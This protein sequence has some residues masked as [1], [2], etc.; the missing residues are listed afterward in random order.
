MNDNNIIPL[1]LR[2]HLVSF[3]MKELVG[4]SR[5][6]AG[7]KCSVHQ[8]ERHSFIYNYLLDNIEK[9][10]YPIKDITGFNIFLNIEAKSRRR[11][12]AKGNFYKVQG[13]GKSFVYLPEKF[14]ED[15]NDLFEQQF[16]T[17]FYS[18]VLARAH[19]EERKTNAI[20]SFIEKYDL[21]EVGVTQIQLRQLFYRISSTGICSPLQGKLKR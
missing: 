14:V 7:F 11:Y 3:L 9:T 8:I 15:I 5:T 12:I 19:D 13:M 17:T 4:E 10:D 18:Y 16:R 6:F 2:P 20:M 21:F 1:K